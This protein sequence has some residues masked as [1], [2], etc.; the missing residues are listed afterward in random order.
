MTAF[1]TAVTAMMTLRGVCFLLPGL[2]LQKTWLEGL[3][4]MQWKRG[5]W[6]S[7]GAR[8]GVVGEEGPGIQTQVWL[9]GEEVTVASGD[10]TPTSS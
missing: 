10:W 5:G 7:E 2:F 3:D 1:T 8:G 9:C 4:Y 6:G